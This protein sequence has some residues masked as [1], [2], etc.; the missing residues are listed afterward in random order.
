MKADVKYSHFSKEDECLWDNI[1]ESPP[2]NWDE[3]EELFAKQVI[4]K[5]SPEEKEKKPE[6][7]GKEVRCSFS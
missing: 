2:E 4:N 7:K 6:K 1:E 5:K 3:F